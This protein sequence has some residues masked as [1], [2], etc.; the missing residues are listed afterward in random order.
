MLLVRL[1]SP[2]PLEARACGLFSLLKMMKGKRPVTSEITSLSDCQRTNEL[3]PRH[4]LA[5]PRGNSNFP[6][7][8]EAA[9]LEWWN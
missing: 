8:K 7:M 3:L 1:I 4:E 6:L 5:V 2:V 9:E